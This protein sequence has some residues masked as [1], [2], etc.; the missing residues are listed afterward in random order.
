MVI[1]ILCPHVK[2]RFNSLFFVADNF[3]EKIIGCVID[4]VHLGDATTKKL[5]MTDISWNYQYMESGIEFIGTP[6]FVMKVL[7]L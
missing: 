2:E 4:G 3:E 1:E 6:F 7:V 5:I